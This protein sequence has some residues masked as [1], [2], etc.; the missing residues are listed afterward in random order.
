MNKFKLLPILLFAL[1]SSTNALAQMYK[2]VDEEGNISYSDQPPY[3]GAETLQAPPL[4]TVPAANTA[5]KKTTASAEPKKVITKYSYLKIVSPENDATV[6]NNAGTL[7][8]SF[9]IK[10]ALNT[11]QGHYFSLTMDGKTV[12]DKLAS[13]SVSLNDVDRGTHKLLISVK[14]KK[15]KTLRKSKPVTVYIHRQSRIRN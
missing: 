3:K 8:I 1:F 5:K 11:E 15:G 13:T 7:S 10:P 12:Q 14:N 4:S 6:R 9:A 2:W